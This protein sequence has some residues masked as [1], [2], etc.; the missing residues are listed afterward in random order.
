MKRFIVIMFVTVFVLG[1][2]APVAFS[3]TDPDDDAAHRAVRGTVKT[4]G[5]AAKGTTETAVSPFVAFWRAITGQGKPEKVV[6]D[7]VEKGGKTIYDAS[8]GTGKTITGQKQ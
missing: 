2:A 1:L 5:E 8:E 4:V 7:P 3:A 6:T